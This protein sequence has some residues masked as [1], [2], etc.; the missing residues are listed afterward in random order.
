MIAGLKLAINVVAFFKRFKILYYEYRTKTFFLVI[1]SKESSCHLL[2]FVNYF[3]KIECNLYML[4]FASE[5]STV[6]CR[7]FS[8]PAGHQFKTGGGKNI[9]KINLLGSFKL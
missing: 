9:K 6:K 4:P 7:V 3:K 8:E 1:F 2:A 5:G